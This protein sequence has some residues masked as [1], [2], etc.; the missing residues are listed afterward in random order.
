MFQDKL[1]QG[2]VVPGPVVE[3]KAGELV[4]QLHSA[5][6]SFRMLQFQCAGEQ[7]PLFF[8]HIGKPLF[9]PLEL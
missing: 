5:V 7:E 1:A 4:S 8:C 2:L 9:Q 3:I 6:N